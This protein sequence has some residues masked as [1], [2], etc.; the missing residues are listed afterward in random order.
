[1][2]LS[3][4]LTV[5]SKQLGTSIQHATVV[6]HKR[7][8][9]WQQPAAKNRSHGEQP[10]AAASSQQLWHEEQICRGLLS[11]DATTERQCSWPQ[12]RLPRC[13]RIQT[14]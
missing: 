12:R 2:H 13:M 7:K 11:C 1:L 6:G 9:K 8:T 4:P 10:A 14:N 3:L 5:A